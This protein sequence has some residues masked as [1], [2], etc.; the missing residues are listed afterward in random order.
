MNFVNCGILVPYDGDDETTARRQDL[1]QNLEQTLF[2]TFITNNSY[3]RETIDS[4][5]EL[6][7]ELIQAIG[8]VRKRIIRRK[9]VLRRPPGEQRS[10]P[11]LSGPGGGTS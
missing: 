2:R 9:E 11:Q 10:I 4:A 3:L 1:R 6:Q 5:D 7:R 8:E